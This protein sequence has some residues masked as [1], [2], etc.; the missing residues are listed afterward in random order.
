[1]RFWTMLGHKYM[2]DVFVSEIPLSCLHSLQ[3]S[4]YTHW[5]SSLRAAWHK[6][7]KDY[8]KKKTG[9]LLFKT[10]AFCRVKS[11]TATAPADKLL[12]KLC[13]A[14]RTRFIF[15]SGAY[16]CQNA[17]F[18][19]AS[20]WFT[21]TLLMRFRR[22]SPNECTK[23]VCWLINFVPTSCVHPSES[24]GLARHILFEVA[25]HGESKSTC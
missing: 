14:R 25:K 9:V 7:Q 12:S 13:F 3:R 18:K 10:R 20:H 4:F 11:E 2:E 6:T 16:L 17:I 5:P 1:M 22:T 23:H 15:F 21:I 8:K 19:K 24:F